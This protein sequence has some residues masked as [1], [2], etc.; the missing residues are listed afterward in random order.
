MPCPA[1]QIWY[2]HA[3]LLLVLSAVVVA[4]QAA[5]P[6]QLLQKSV[7]LP[8]ALANMEVINARLSE[9][10]F[11]NPGELSEFGFLQPS[12]S[13]LRKL[14]NSNEASRRTQESNSECQVALLQVLPPPSFKKY[15]ECTREKS[16]STD[17][18]YGVVG[19]AMDVSARC[20]CDNKVKES[21]DALG[22]CDHPD[23]KQSCELQ[24]E[25]DCTSAEAQ[26]CL[27]KCPPIC[28]E[29]SLAP[30]SCQEDC[31][32]GE[33]H[34]YLLCITDHSKNQTALGNL[35]KT[36][37][38]VAFTQSQEVK[39]YVECG[40]GFPKRTYWQRKNSQMHCACEHDLAKA[41][42]RSKCCDTSWATG[43]C[44]MK[45][46]NCADPTNCASETAKECLNQCREKCTFQGAHEVMTECYNSCL[47]ASSACHL[48]ATCEPLEQL[49][50]DYVCDDGQ[51]PS[52]NGCCAIPAVGPSGDMIV[53]ECPTLC[54]SRQVHQL[55][56]GPE[57]LCQGC[58][59]N[60]EE[61]RA[62]F[63]AVLEHALW[64]NG[65]QI[66]LE[67]AHLAQLKRGPTPEMQRLMAERNE[68]LMEAFL[69]AETNAEAEANMMKINDKYVTL[70]VEAAKAAQN[71]DATLRAAIQSGDKDQIAL[72]LKH[73]NGA[74][75]DPALE[76]EAEAKLDGKIKQEEK[77]QQQQQQQEQEE[78]QGLGLGVVLGIVAGVVVFMSVGFAVFWFASKKS[79]DVPAN[80]EANPPSANG[81][82]VVV[83]QPVNGTQATSGAPAQ[84]AVQG[85]PMAAKGS[86]K[87][88]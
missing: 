31:V 34:K 37:D 38:E 78:S 22:C 19:A 32:T 67:I 62:K 17:V 2:R 35:E 80:Y 65:Q 15:A 20:W 79:K 44:D 69:T 54:D 42:E 52:A 36:C 64:V 4:S 28:L 50:F 53:T 8:A 7:Q 76:A 58:P 55:P 49:S 5:L 81:T 33:C 59:K 23:F 45:A 73:T 87:A 56:H 27:D 24:C 86:E 3:V 84:E 25:P 66:L 18:D 1:S 43:M 71:P 41:A 47:S 74:G 77:E 13:H 21:V 10:N 40:A 61:M 26:Q 11:K 16:Q 9:M 39:S 57:C 30:P 60:L 14:M 29:P 68:K 46:Q 12:Q 75:G 48:Y 88:T 51:T 63:K 6:G 72:A 82:T 85:A 70:I 83:G